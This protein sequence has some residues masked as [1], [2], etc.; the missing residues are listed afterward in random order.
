MYVQNCPHCDPNSSALKHPLKIT[1]NFRVVCDVHPLVEGHI[2]IIPKDHF[3]CVG[4]FPKDLFEE[5]LI[6]YQEASAFLKKE[7][8]TVSSFEHGVIGQTV[9]H[10]HVHLL[11]FQGN[12]E[13]IVPEG[14][15]NLT[16][17]TQLVSLLKVFETEGK[18]LFFS[19]G[20]K[21]WLVQTSLGA[22]L[23]FRDRFARA[24]GTPERGDW[25]KME[26]DQK[27]MESAQ[28]DIMN[29]EKKWKDLHA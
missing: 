13:M 12:S 7:Y 2:L 6:L 21:L 19:I 14:Q 9:F 11:P 5:F 27:I 18:Y 24:R 22:P 20:E 4:A 25:K 10:S 23:F 26:Q 29:L 28:K 15:T 3:S 1:K 16:P 8:Q 17:I